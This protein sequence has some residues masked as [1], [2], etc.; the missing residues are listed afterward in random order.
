MRYILFIG[1]PFNIASGSCVRTAEILPPLADMVRRRDGCGAFLHIPANSLRYVVATLAVSDGPVAAGE[2][3]YRIVN[4]SVASIRKAGIAVDSELIEESVARAVSSVKHQERLYA[5]GSLLRRVLGFGEIYVERLKRYEKPC[6]DALAKGLDKGSFD[7]CGAYGCDSAL[8]ISFTLNEISRKRRI[9]SMVMLQLEPFQ[10]QSVGSWASMKGLSSLQINSQVRSLFKSMMSS[11]NLKYLL[12]VSPAPLQLSGLGAVAQ[13]YG[14]GLGIP[15]PANGIDKQVTQMRKVSGKGPLAVYFGRLTFDK[16]AMDLLR[17]WK[18]VNS[19]LPEAK[20]KVIGA[21][22]SE[23][24]SAAFVAFYQ[25]LRL[26][27]VE[28]LGFMQSRTGLFREVGKARIL[29]Y[30][31]YHDAYPLVVLE[32]IGLGL[33]VVGYHTLALDYLCRELPPVSLV[34]SGDFRTLGLR[35][36]ELLGL[37]DKKF[38]EMQDSAKVGKFLE[39]HNSWEKVAAAELPF[40]EALL[41]S[42]GQ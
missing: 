1:A 2:R 35:A 20:L 7:L 11:G 40:L 22:E 39:A 10:G 32:S 26:E 25:E 18:V 13:K 21:F 29:L 28:F 16:G 15:Y 12:S 27:N 17:A 42:P 38:C 6:V 5:H 24:Q 4:G 14:V 37:D 34:P 3:T 9:P 33:A 30:P 41:H 31:S 36:A 23:K 8:E 19:V